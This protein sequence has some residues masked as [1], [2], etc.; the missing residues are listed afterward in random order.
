MRVVAAV[1]CMGVVQGAFGTIFDVRDYGA[2][3]DGK[4]K[5]TKAVQKAIDAAVAAGGG[6]VLVGAGTYVCGSLFLGDNIDLHL[7]PGAVIRASAD[8]SD[9]NARAVCP[10]NWGCAAESVDGQHLL[11]AIEKRNVTVRGPGKV[12]GNGAA[13]LL[14]PK[15]GLPWGHDPSTPKAEFWRG[16]DKIPFRP[17]QMLYF[18]EC[19]NVRLTDL[20]LADSSYWNVF[21]HG[22]E[23]V[24]VRGLNIHNESR[25]FHTHNGDGIDID[26][27]RYVTVSGCLIDVADDCITLRA[28]GAGLKRPGDCAYVT[29][30]NCVLSTICNG[31]RAGVGRG[32]VHDVTMDNIVFNGG[33]G[34]G[35]AVNF[36]GAWEP[37]EH[38]VDFENVRCSN[39]IVN[40]R[41]LIHLYPNK[42]KV[43][44]FRNLA[45]V[46][47]TGAATEPSE[48]AG[49][50][51]APAERIRFFDVDVKTSVR[52]RS[53]NDLVVERC[54]FT[55]ER[56]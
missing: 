24:V 47:F 31:L 55:V 43:S 46:H 3:G 1:L 35:T 5:D 14:D 36:V 26:S 40:C 42:A 41:R 25:R 18:V 20:E 38:G 17:A 34:R 2:T 44:H 27:C 51:E 49:A 53:V 50:A 11:L 10:Q 13:F 15:T 37:C 7:G 48:V 16:Q 28:D 9:Y 54:A 23:H 45:L 6:E 29:V 19:D 30:A 56:Q 52:V 8:R 33:V 39:W 4:T 21:L 32:R 12:D 22:C